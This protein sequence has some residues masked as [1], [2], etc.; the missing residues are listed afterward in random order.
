LVDNPAVIGDLRDL[1]AEVALPTLDFSP[2]R[3]EL[4]RTLNREGITAIAWLTL[5]KADGLYTDNEPQAEERVRAFEEWTRSNGLRWA[6]VGLDIEPN[7]AQLETLKQHKWR[8]MR[9]LLWRAF[10]GGRIRRAQQEYSS[11]IRGLQA[12]GYVVQT[13]QMPYVPA[14]RDAH[15][16]VLDRLLGTVDVRGNEEYLMLYTSFA[17]QVGAGMIW[18]LWRNAQGIAVGSTDAAAGAGH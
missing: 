11:L 9:T 16:T 10:D 3:A 7:F 13:Y 12:Q 5:S 2:E 18:S 4:V 8:L 1:G 6:A 17:P 14:E 15:S